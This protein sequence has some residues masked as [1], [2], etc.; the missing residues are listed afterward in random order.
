MTRTTIALLTALA[1]SLGACGDDEKPAAA[2]DATVSVQDIDGVGSVLVD[3]SGRALYTADQESDGSIR[4]RGGCAAVWLP[5]EASGTPTGSDDVSGE[6]GSIERPDGV[7]QVTYDGKPL[8]RFAEDA[9][10]GVVTGDG[11]SDDFGGTTFTWHAVTADG[12]STG[13]GGRSYGY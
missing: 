6:L 2:A 11:L 4:C 7:M 3:R 8:Y 5:L 10:P 1:L 13:G 12:A 9:E